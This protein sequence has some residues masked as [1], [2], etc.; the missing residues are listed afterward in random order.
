MLC[1][2]CGYIGEKGSDRFGVHLCNVCFV[3]APS[4]KEKFEAY[5]AE[6]VD[7]KALDTFRER[8]EMPG[9]KQK[10]G[11]KVKAAK[12]IVMS[13]AAFGYDVVNGELVLNVDSGTVHTL[14]RDF[15]EGQWSLNAL[16]KKYGF[17]LTGLK[18]IL[19]NRTYLGEIK[20]DAQIH[21]ATHK[22]LIKPSLFYAVQRKLEG[23]LRPRGKLAN[24]HVL[25]GT[26]EPLKADNE[27]R[28]TDSLRS[29]SEEEKDRMKG[30]E[31]KFVTREKEKATLKKGKHSL[32]DSGL[33]L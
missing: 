11:M 27:K 14:F 25:A 28:K 26:A 1:Y 23:Y 33:G 8:G 18:K 19:M 21:K 3:F 13:R 9:I 10:S 4:V 22:A 2:K 7:W 30:N 29:L 20:F 16:S 17:S 32:Y 5:V 12:G 6:A 31:E 15:L 24:K